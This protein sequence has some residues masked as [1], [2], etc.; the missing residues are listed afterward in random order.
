MSTVKSTV[1][2]LELDINTAKII[3]QKQADLYDYLVEQFDKFKDGEKI[4]LTEQDKKG[5]NVT[6]SDDNLLKH[7]NNTANTIAGL[8][9]GSK[10]LQDMQ[11]MVKILDILMELVPVK[12]FKKIP[13]E[14]IKGDLNI[15]QS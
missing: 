13:I 5:D 3:Q 4:E 11:R 9:R 14:L 10:T 1:K 7:I 8:E 6:M 12:D 15:S 2:S